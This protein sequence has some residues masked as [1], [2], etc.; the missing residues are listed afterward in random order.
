LLM[1]LS[2]SQILYS[3]IFERDTLD[4]PY[5]AFLIYHGAKDVRVI[6][7]VAEHKKGHP[8][9]I[10]PLRT[11]CDLHNLNLDQ[12]VSEVE[13]NYVCSAVHP[14]MS[15]HMHFLSFVRD[16]FLRALP[17]YV[18]LHAITALI[19]LYSKRHQLL[20][21]YFRASHKKPPS[22]EEIAENKDVRKA[23]AR[24]LFTTLL[25]FLFNT[26]RSCLFLGTYCGLAW[27]H[28]CLLTRVLD[29]SRM[30]PRVLRITLCVSGLA[31]WIEE[32]SRRMELAMYCLPK[33]IE[34]GMKNLQKYHLLPRWMSKIKHVDI[35]L[36]CVAFAAT[37]FCYQNEAKSV[38]P[39]YFSVMEW[40]WGKSGN[41]SGEKEDDM[42]GVI[43]E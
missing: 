18:P 34:S 22:R 37:I 43:D 17:L 28:G 25:R 12:V 19:V 8:L 16:G 27:Y 31:S 10:E 11:Y 20:D 2:A 7:S 40:L 41:V 26:A 30:K 14:H 1:C 5:R 6:N 39:T 21:R 36:F 24:I 3:Y 15:C 38:K 23:R 33:A 13:R 42:R 32:K 4:P 35:V 29:P 9:Q